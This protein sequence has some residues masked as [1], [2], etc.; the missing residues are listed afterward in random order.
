[1]NA[2]A[3][4]L[5]MAM[6]MHITVMDHSRSAPLRSSAFHAGMQQRGEKHEED[7]MSRHAPL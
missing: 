4:T 1:M 7:E 2:A 6:A 3:T 5:A